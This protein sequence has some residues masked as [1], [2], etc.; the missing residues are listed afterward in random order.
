MKIK[1]LILI[2]L[3]VSTNAISQVT[4]NQVDDFED[5]TTQDWSGAGP[6]NITTDGPAGVNDNYLQITATGAGTAGSRV[7]VHNSI[8]WGGSYPS[9]GV[10]GIRFDGRV[11]TNDLVLRIA[12]N[13]AGGAICSTTGITVTAGSGWTSVTIPID[14]SSMQTVPGNGNV[15]DGTDV[16]LTLSN[17]TQFRII[18]SPSP[19]FQGEVIAAVLELDNITALTSLGINDVL[20]PNDFK[21]SP[22][23]SKSK[24]NLLLPSSTITVKLEVFDVLGKKVMSKEVSKLSSSIDVS[25]W[26]NGVYLVRITSENGAQTKRFIKQ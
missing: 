14:A 26:N 8:Q 17:C 1:L 20:Q 10:I 3:F 5:G 2:L 4:A 11:L 25:K 23:P 24:L 12:M 15:P 7:A 21:I 19:S 18:S 16:G 6:V 22:N 13:G 9:Q